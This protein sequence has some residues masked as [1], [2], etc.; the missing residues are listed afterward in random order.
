MTCK[1]MESWLIQL[2]ERTKQKK[3]NILLFMDNATSH[4]HL[5][6]SNIKLIF[7]PPNTTSV[8][9][10]M[11]Q[12]VIYTTKMYYRKKVLSRLC[13]E[14]DTVE[15]MSELCK[16]IHV[17]D[18]IQWL[19]SA[20]NS[21]SKN[22]VEGAFRKAGFNFSTSG[23]NIDP[24]DDVSVSYLA[25]L[26][27]QTNCSGMTISEFISIDNDVF[28]ECDSMDSIEI[29]EAIEMAEADENESETESGESQNESQSEPREMLTSNEVIL[30]AERLKKTALA[31][32]NTRP[33]NKISDC[34]MIIEEE[35]SKRI[36]KQTTIGDFFTK[37]N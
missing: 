16:T 36:C 5:N 19:A 1:I 33:F 23:D 13:R 29:A 37:K 15:N 31:K 6:L 14:M 8:L 10:P 20:V 2:N 22:C 30:Y 4:P 32:G 7:F 3:R 28:T 21:V 17:L 35:I 26:M 27:R 34:I 12:G 25:S 11:D 18:A 24:E 9:Q